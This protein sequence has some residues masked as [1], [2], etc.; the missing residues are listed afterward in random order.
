MSCSDYSDAGKGSQE[1]FECFGLCWRA[2]GKMLKLYYRNRFCVDAVA[3][4]PEQILRVLGTVVRQ[5][6]VGT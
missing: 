6:G 3:D 4:D 1:D 5:A 2:R